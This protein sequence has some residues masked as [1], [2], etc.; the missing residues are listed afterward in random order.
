[1][2]SRSIA[3]MHKRLISSSVDRSTQKRGMKVRFRNVIVF[4]KTAP[5]KSQA[6]RLIFYIICK[7][8]SLSA[9]LE[10]LNI[11]CFAYIQ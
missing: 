7:S 3:A 10:K 5:S 1:M 2:I 11:K 9:R 6:I 8:A 4:V